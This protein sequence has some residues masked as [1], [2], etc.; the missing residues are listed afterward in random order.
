MATRARPGAGEKTQQRPPAPAQQPAPPAETTIIVGDE[1]LNDDALER[2]DP[3]ILP[4]EKLVALSGFDF[5]TKVIVVEERI[6]TW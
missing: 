5:E 6:L 4:D 1:E 3:V 2:I